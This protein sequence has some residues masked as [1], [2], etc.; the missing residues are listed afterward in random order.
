MLTMKIKMQ[1]LFFPNEDTH[2]M[3][4]DDKAPKPRHQVCQALPQSM[5]PPP[6][7]STSAICHHQ[8]QALLTRKFPPHQAQLKDNRKRIV[9]EHQT[10]SLSFFII[11]I[12]YHFILDHSYA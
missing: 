2:D 6:K 10:V 1:G 9:A 12:T 4:P 11:T 3:T 7:S 5:P 8:A